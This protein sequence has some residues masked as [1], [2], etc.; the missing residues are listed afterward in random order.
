[1]VLKSDRNFAS[2]GPFCF[3]I[4]LAIVHP[5]GFIMVFESQLK[6]ITEIGYS[7]EFNDKLILS[8]CSLAAIFAVHTPLIYTT[9]SLLFE[10]GF[11]F[12]PGTS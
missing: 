5:D 10:Q 4:D 6:P 1:M 3:A 8:I 12:N 9:N 2:F 11:P 7:F